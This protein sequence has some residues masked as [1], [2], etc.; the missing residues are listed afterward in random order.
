MATAVASPPV[1][2]PNGP[3]PLESG[4]RLTSGE[5]ERRYAEHP[6]VRRAELVEGVVYV[7]SPMRYG[8]HAELQ[9][10]ISGWLF[11]YRT[12]VANVNGGDSPTVRLDADNNVQPDS[13]LRYEDGSSKRTE[14]G[15]LVGPPELVVEIAA[16]TASIDLG[17]KLTAYRRNGVQEYIA[18][19]VHESRLDWFWLNSDGNY[20]TLRPDGR[21][22]IES[23]VFP[24]LR[25]A[26]DK[27]LAGDFAGV[28]AEQTRKRRRRA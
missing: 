26:V 9:Q 19:Q 6:E 4:M 18:W 3:A 22:V 12:T 17:P 5:F 24:G 25:L 28:L 14:D 20:E 7:A 1:T 10:V 27:L 15:Y 11:A 2:R 21:G 8:D 23:R 13:I 16:S